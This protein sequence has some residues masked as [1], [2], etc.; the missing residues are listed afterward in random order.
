MKPFSK[1]RRRLRDLQKCFE[2]YFL[3]VKN[4]LYKND[5]SY[6][7][8]QIEKDHLFRDKINKEF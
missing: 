1:P 5:Y 7:F 8:K 4:K 2:N 3:E 6:Y